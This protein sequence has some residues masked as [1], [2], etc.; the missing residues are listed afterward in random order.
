MINLSE[1][2]RQSLG[3]KPD[4]EI[5]EELLKSICDELMDLP[6]D[7]KIDI[8]E[9]DEDILS[10]YIDSRKVMTYINGEYKM[11]DKD[12]VNMVNTK[13]H[14][15]NM[16]YLSPSIFLSRFAKLY[17]ELHLEGE[18]FTLRVEKED[19]ENLSEFELEEV[20]E[21]LNSYQ[22]KKTSFY[23]EDIID[24]KNA[25]KLKG[26]PNLQIF[27][28]I[29]QSE[30]ESISDF[31]LEKLEEIKDN[32]NIEVYMDNILTFETD[33][34]KNFSNVTSYFKDSYYQEKSLETVKAIAEK[35]KELTSDIKDTDS[36]FDKFSKIYTK[37]ARSMVYDYEAKELI[38]KRS[39]G[40]ELL[41]EEENKIRDSQNQMGLLTRKN[42][43]WR[44]FTYSTGYFRECRN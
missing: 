22:V 5:T 17:R 20:K 27:Y 33:K 28:T 11:F 19:L 6:T 4:Q 16:A 8:T 37:L 36:E 29:N 42:G 44:I 15:L 35:I 12:Y 32:V 3:I 7:S 24:I 2:A 40:I 30:L 41:P 25:D 18:E 14:D 38:L 34:L 10:N 21:R 1:V 43:L 13:I 39:K 26:F 23:M 9:Q 31:E